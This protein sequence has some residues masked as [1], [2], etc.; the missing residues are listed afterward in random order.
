[1]KNQSPSQADSVGTSTPRLNAANVAEN[2]PSNGHATPTL[3]TPRMARQGQATTPSQSN[4]TQVDPALLPPPHQ[5]FLDHA[6][7]LPAAGG[8]SFSLDEGSNPA[9]SAV[10]TP[11]EDNT[12]APMTWDELT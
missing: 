10:E 5:G 12:L 2:S 4:P 7:S 9:A 1:M 6:M 8:L 3:A 11:W